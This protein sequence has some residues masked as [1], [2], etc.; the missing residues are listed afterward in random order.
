MVL[1]LWF[2]ICGNGL[3]FRIW[4]LD[5]KVDGSVVRVEGTC[6]AR[7]FRGTVRDTCAPPLRTLPPSL[8]FGVEDEE[9]A[10]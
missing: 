5:L 10:F 7:F 4:A 1:G 8:V 3:W 2:R 9:F 6:R